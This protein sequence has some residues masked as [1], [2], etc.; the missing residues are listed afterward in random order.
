LS[1]IRSDMAKSMPEG[2]ITLDQKAAEY[3]GTTTRFPSMQLNVGGGDDGISW[4]RNGVSIPSMS[5]LQALFDALFLETDEAHK[6]RLA[7]S[8][9]LNS[10]IL[11]LVREDASDLKRRLSSNDVE[12]LDEYFTSVREVE[13][14]L[15]MSEAW[16]NKAKPKVDYQLPKPLPTSFYEEVPLYYDLIKLALITDSTR[17][18]TYSINGWSGDSGLPGVRQGY[19]ALTH[20]GQDPTRLKELTIIETFHA[21]Q[22]AR[23][24]GDLKRTQVEGESSLLDRTMVLFGSGMGNASSHSNR[25]LPLILAGGGFIHGEHKDFPKVGEKQ[26]P[27][28]NLY[29]SMLQRFGLEID[30]FGTSSGTLEGLA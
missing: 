14:R 13:K 27:A 23:F 28:C 20:H 5:H 25:D 26:T 12:K 10:S 29:L 6:R 30:H 2:N 4:T 24:L 15:Q 9:K 7:R 21:A 8:Y 11:D 22:L 3:V 16:L 19:H 1:G 17:I 18:L